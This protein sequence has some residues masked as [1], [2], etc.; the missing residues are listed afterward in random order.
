MILFFVFRLNIFT[1][2]ISN[3]L[4]PLGSKRPGSLNLTQPVRYPIN[5]SMMLFYDLSIC[6]VV[7]AFSLFGTSKVL[8]G[9]SQRL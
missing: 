7:A 1:S 5:I 6:F 2:K 4:L 9:D 8:I 3:L